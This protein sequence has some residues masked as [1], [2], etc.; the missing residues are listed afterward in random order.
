MGIGA[1]CIRP[2]TRWLPE[3][4]ADAVQCAVAVYAFIVLWF[5]WGVRAVFTFVRNALV[6]PVH[7]IRFHWFAVR[8]KWYAVRFERYAVGIRRYAIW[9][10]QWIIRS[11]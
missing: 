4:A 10:G 1:W 5:Q 2:D 8:L 11:A 9:R 6:R 7:A 3:L